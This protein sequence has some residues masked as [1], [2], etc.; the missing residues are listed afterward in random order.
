MSYTIDIMTNRSVASP[1]KKK[2]RTREGKSKSSFA[3]AAVILAERNMALMVKL[4]PTLPLPPILHKNCGF[5]FNFRMDL[6]PPPCVK[7]ALSP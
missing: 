3:A 6:P 2:E 4:P 7:T 5:T 1:E